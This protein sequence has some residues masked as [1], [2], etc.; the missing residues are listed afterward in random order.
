MLQGKPTPYQLGDVFVEYRDVRSYPH[1]HHYPDGSK[2]IQMIYFISRKNSNGTTLFH[3]LYD[4]QNSLNRFNSHPYTRLD[5]KYTTALTQEMHKMLQHRNN[6]TLHYEANFASPSSN[7]FSCFACRIDS[8]EE[9]FWEHV[10]Y[11]PHVQEYHRLISQIF[12][13]DKIDEREKQRLLDVSFLLKDT[14]PPFLIPSLPHF[15]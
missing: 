1:P 3:V 7:Q 13:H 11:I 2:F 15:L 6:P 14:M 8:P 10:C 12:K 4:Y 5:D 9:I